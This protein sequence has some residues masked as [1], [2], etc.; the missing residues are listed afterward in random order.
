MAKIT[1]AELV[2]GCKKNNPKIQRQ[3]YETYSG[4]ML[5]ICR[6]YIKHTDEAEEIMVNGFLKIFE[7]IGQFKEEGSFEGWM[8]KIM[9]FESLNHLR[10]QKMVFVEVEAAQYNENIDYTNAQTNLEVQDLMNL[11]DE[12]PPGYRAVFNLYAIEGYSHQEI[13]D[14]LQISESTSKSQLSRA[15]AHLQKKVL[16][17]NEKLK[18][19]YGK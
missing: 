12:L 4:R 15:K 18:I 17:L 10:K 16:D 3:L 5:A 9:V 1:E 2:K 6:R 19:E 13:A 11:L 14:M 7:K 8:K